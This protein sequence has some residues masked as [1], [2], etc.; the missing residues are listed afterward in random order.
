MSASE[1]LQKAVYEALQGDAALTALVADRVYD[2]PLSG[3]AYPYISF[4]PTDF[5][6]ERQD[7][8]KR[9]TETFQIDVWADDDMDRAPCKAICNAV[10][11]LLDQ[12]RLSLDDPYAMGRC[13]LRLARVMDDPDGITK[14][15][16]LQFEAEVQTQ[17]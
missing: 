17:V 8:F 10:V 5:Y 4:G 13:E 9:R 14:H 3:A 12:A 7:C 2:V 16:V 11:A 15:G 1:A 6:P